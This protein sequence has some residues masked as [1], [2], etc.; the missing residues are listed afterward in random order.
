MR[1]D[2][3]EAGDPFLPPAEADRRDVLE[4]AL[5]LLAAATRG[6]VGCQT[7]AVSCGALDAILQCLQHKQRAT[8][9]AAATALHEAIT[10]NHGAQASCASSVDTSVSTV[11]VLCGFIP[12]KTIYEVNY[13]IP[14]DAT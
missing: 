9:S 13:Y 4:D 3:D 5:Q 1:D 2:S 11:V 6:H 10:G 14:D 8:Q 7:E 12:S